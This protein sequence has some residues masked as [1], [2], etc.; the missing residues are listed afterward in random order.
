[1]DQTYL[2]YN[3]VPTV[4][5]SA[6]TAAA[7]GSNYSALDAYFQ[8][9]KTKTTT[10]SGKLTDQFSFTIP[11]LQWNQQTQSG[12]QAGFGARWRL[13]YQSA[14]VG[15]PWVLRIAFVEPASPADLA[16]LK[17]GT[18]VTRING[19]DI[20]T[21]SYNQIIAYIFPSG[22]TPTTFTA[23]DVGVA[24]SRDVTVTPSNSVLT[25]PVPLT[26]VL[27]SGT[28]KV[29]YLVLNTF[30]VASAEQ[31]LVQAISNLKSQNVSELVLDLRYNSGG[32]VTISSEL[33]YMIGG[34]NLNGQAF[35]KYICN[36][37]NPFA[38]CG[39]NEPFDATTQGFSLT[40][41]Q[42]LPQL[43]LT[44]VYVL[45]TAGTCSASESIIN[46]LSPFVN[47]VRIGSTT[48][49]K[50]YGFLVTDN[51]GTSYAA[52]Q[53]KGANA[54]G[55]GDYADGFAPT[56][57]V[58]DDLSHARGDPNELMLSGALTHINT[59][60]CPPASTGILK[61]GAQST[62]LRELLLTQPGE[63]QRI[64]GRPGAPQ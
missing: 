59:G 34:A 58:A 5:A 48:C 54:S 45:T 39:T 13:I 31:Q 38:F 21:L 49:G 61:P 44:R 42:P 60:V 33:G 26:T 9:L 20:N 36:D 1:M 4:D 25:T 37:R 63:E 16:G 10:A 52:I 12:V 11:T 64:I 62:V 53:F 8:A 57:P 15:P 56:C 47:V 43:G 24:T 27:T 30:N 51:C 50:P 32:Y 3:Q 23:Q 35:E 40:A 29:G 18:S 46:G 7:Y 17:R 22:T 14:N 41:G 19:A 55:F 6:Y 28:K 2:W